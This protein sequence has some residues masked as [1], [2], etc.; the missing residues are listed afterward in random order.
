MEIKSL[1]NADFETIYRAFENAFSDYEVRI[2]DKELRAMMKRRGFDQSLSFAAFVEEEIV[3]FTLNGVGHFN[4]LKTAYD[5][6]TGTIQGFR[7]KGLATKIFEYSLPFLKQAGI[8]QYLLEVLQQNHKAISVYQNIG[9]EISREFYYFIRKNEEI[10][11]KKRNIADCVIKA[12]EVEELKAVEMFWDFEPSWQ[13][14]FESIYRVRSTFLIL[15]AFVQ[16]LLVAYIVFDSSSGDIAQFAVEKSYRRR[17]IAST[18]FHEMQLQNKSKLTK[19]INIDIHCDSLIE[20][21]RSKNFEISGK[22][23]EM[24]YQF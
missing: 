16:E 22:Q 23:F 8:Q 3:A 1:V 9:F 11:N 2:N 18:L 7:G 13:N 6:G 4:H 10:Q 14:N 12:V 24:I 15:G 5:T 20:F 21:L 17:G 19:L